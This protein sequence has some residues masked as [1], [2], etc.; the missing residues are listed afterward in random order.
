MG[1]R[2]C[3]GEFLDSA[4]FCRT[5]ALDLAVSRQMPLTIPSFLLEP[6]LHDCIDSRREMN[7]TALRAC[8]IGCGHFADIWLTAGTDDSIDDLDRGV[9]VCG[10]CL[11]AQKPLPLVF[12]EDLREA[13]FP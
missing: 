2:L 10:R 7:P 1:I 6:L 8:S 3:D 5:H 9:F 12:R 13:A 11:E 4:D